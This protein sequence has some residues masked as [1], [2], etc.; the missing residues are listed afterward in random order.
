LSD[1]VRGTFFAVLETPDGGAYHVPLDARAAEQLRPGDLVAFATRPV[2]AVRA[3]DRELAEK[4]QSARGLYALDREVAASKHPHARRLKELE[5]IGLATA[6]GPNQWRLAPTLLADLQERHRRDP[7]RHRM[8]IEKQNLALDQQVGH[9]GEVWLDRLEPGTLAHH[10][11]G[12]DFRRARERRDEVLRG[13]GIEPSDPNRSR[14]LD[15]LE[16][17][18]VGRDHAQRA[19]V[20]FV[21]GLVDGFRG[22]VTL[23]GSGE[24]PDGYAVVSDGV[25]CVVL[26]AT[27]LLRAVQG[28]SVELSRDSQG[29][30]VVQRVRDLDR[31]R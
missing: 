29:R 23:A 3:V 1:E 21:P 4:A 5:G 27:P 31:G 7:V 25:Q 8:R 14:K 26:R 12:A 13:W 2:E 28:S 24:R 20:A 16:R 11:L 15:E 10:G 30:L 19:G 22:R 18:A 9:R 17:Q 6:T